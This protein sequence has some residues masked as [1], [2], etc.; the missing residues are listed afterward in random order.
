MD[1]AYQGKGYATEAAKAMIDYMFK[2]V[3]NKWYFFRRCKR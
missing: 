3:E 1:P 2:E